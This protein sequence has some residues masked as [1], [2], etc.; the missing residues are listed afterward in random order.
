M[1][2]DDP[3]D[4]MDAMGQDDTPLVEPASNR[5]KRIDAVSFV[6]GLL[7]IAIGVLAVADRIWADIDPVLVVGG[8]VAAVGMALIISVISRQRRQGNQQDT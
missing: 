8:S 6:A 2:A 3:D 4:A 1:S 5:R 7:F